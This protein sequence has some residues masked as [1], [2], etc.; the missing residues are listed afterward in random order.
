MQFAFVGRDFDSRRR[1]LVIDEKEIHLFDSIRSMSKETSLRCRLIDQARAQLERLIQSEALPPISL[2]LSFLI[3]SNC[4]RFSL[5]RMSNI[6]VV[7]ADREKLSLM[8]SKINV[9]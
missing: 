1:S 2:S 7:K 9:T 4:A 3:Q 8:S 5:Q 6:V